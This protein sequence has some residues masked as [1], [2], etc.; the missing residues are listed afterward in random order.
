MLPAQRRDM[1]E[2]MVRN[3]PMRVAQMGDGPFDIDRVPVYDCADDE[4]ETGRAER[5]AFERSVT[6]LSAL[7][8]ED[9]ALQFMC[10]FAL[11]EAG[12]ATP[13]QCQT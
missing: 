3:R 4:I 9:G 8:E 13:A 12:L 6:D 7:V 11:V 1:L 5:L 2:Q 10:S